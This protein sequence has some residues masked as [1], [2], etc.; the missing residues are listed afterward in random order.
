MVAA[1]LD[2]NA[3]YQ[4]SETRVTNVSAPINNNLQT[5]NAGLRV[6]AKTAQAW[7][8]QP[9]GDVEGRY[10]ARLNTSGVGQQLSV[11]YKEDEVHP[12]RTIGCLRRTESD[13]SQ[14]WDISEWGKLV[15]RENGRGKATS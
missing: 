11:C 13:E 15:L 12:S 3:W 1:K 14:Q 10:L 6:F 7:Q 5:T 4:V 9:F 2:A 8:F